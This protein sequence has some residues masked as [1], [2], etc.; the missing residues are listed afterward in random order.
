MEFK[1]VRKLSEDQAREY[2]ESIRWPD[3]AACVHCGSVEV[4]KLGGKAANRGVYKCRTKECRKQFTVTV[5]TI[6][7]RSH[8]PL[9]TWIEAFSLV[10]SSKK[11]I[12]ALQLQRML[13]LGSYQTAWHMAHRI[14]HAMDS[15]P[16]AGM[17]GGEGKDVIAD[18]SFFGGKPG[19]QPLA[20]RRNRRQGKSDKVAVFGLVEPGGRARSFPLGRGKT[21]LRDLSTHLKANASTKSRLLTDESMAYKKVGP[22]FEGGHETVNHARSQYVRTTDAGK[23]S[24]NEIEAYWALL[25]RGV[26]GT[27]HHVSGEHLHRYCNEF[28]FRWS[29]RNVSDGERTR[30]ALKAAD[31]KMLTYRQPSHTA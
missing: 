28:S 11:G 4:T 21:A 18:E 31:G 13:G 24:T 8:I 14:R 6:F 27:F 7:H 12:S 22:E 1:E 26:T 15:E 23:I 29:Y 3:G 10:C 2:L 17:L 25:K 9:K 19:N 20:K 16:L 30:I 5:G